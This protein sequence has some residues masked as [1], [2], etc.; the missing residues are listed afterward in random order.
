[1]KLANYQKTIVEMEKAILKLLSE[2]TED[3]ILDDE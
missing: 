2:T 1:M 3:K